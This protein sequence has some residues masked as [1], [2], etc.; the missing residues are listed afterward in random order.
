MNQYQLQYFTA[1]SSGRIVR[2]GFEPDEPSTLGWSALYRRICA[3]VSSDDELKSQLVPFL[4]SDQAGRTIQILFVKNSHLGNRIFYYNLCR[5][6]KLRRVESPLGSKEMSLPEMTQ[7]P[8][9]TI[10]LYDIMSIYE[11]SPGLDFEPDTE[12]IDWKKQRIENKLLYKINLDH[13]VK[14]LDSS[15]W[16]RYIPL[17]TTVEQVGETKFD[18]PE[19]SCSFD[20]R[21]AALLKK[22]IG[23]YELGLYESVAA[24]TTLEFNC[25]MLLNSFIQKAGDRGHHE[26]VT[27]FKF[28]SETVMEQKCER[29]IQF[30]EKERESGKKLSDLRWNMLMVDDHSDTP[31]SS[32]KGSKQVNSNSHLSNKKSIIGKLL[33]A[34]GKAGNSRLNIEATGITSSDKEI[35]SQGVKKLKET[36][37]D[38]ILLD[39]LLGQSESNPKLKAYGHEFLL[40]M[41]TGSDRKLLHRGPMGR[42]WVFPISSFPHAFTDKLH[43][44]NIDGSNR[45]WYIA[46][47]GDPITTPELFRTNFYRLI[48]RQITEYYLHEAALTRWPSQFMGI[49]DKDVWRKAVESQIHIEQ[50][51]LKLLANHRENS[52]FMEE[53]EKFLEKQ[54][55][56]LA[57]WKNLEEWLKKVEQYKRGNSPAE[58]ITGLHVL[59]QSHSGFESVCKS[60]EEQLLAFTYNA[61]TSLLERAIHAKTNNYTQVDFNDEPLFHFPGEL[62]K[63]FSGLKDLNVSG[64]KLSGLP[65]SIAGLLKLRTLNLSNNSNLMHIP[66]SDMLA[67]CVE[68]RQLNLRGT[69]I[70]QVLVEKNIEPFANSRPEVLNLL[71]AVQEHCSMLNSEEEKGNTIFIS[72]AREASIMKSRLVTHLV[73]LRRMG[74]VTIWDDGETIPGQEWNA[75]I[76]KNLLSAQIILLLID[77]DFMASNY[78]WEV[79]IPLA[80]ERHEQKKCK[81]IPIYVNHIYSGVLT[82][83]KYQSLPMGPEEPI[84]SFSNQDRAW[85]LVAAGVMRVVMSLH[86]K[87]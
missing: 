56:Y 71:K 57:F 28:H 1:D 15:I 18:P 80:Q 50:Q 39:Y 9:I 17:Y 40:E 2:L 11:E 74:L 27:P 35:I 33:T 66:A 44:L 51:K 53:M 7:C 58:L 46:Y 61:E 77:A 54:A 72:Y 79:E 67:H 83:K 62:P 4:Q 8:I 41:A 38:I 12:I 14:F 20:K 59:H 16:Q 60:L 29:L 85:S 25:R 86:D 64:C 34:T 22:I 63:V 3:I 31:L 45:R 68:L 43:Q 55:Q 21:M 6:G 76:K 75:E 23:Y 82:L 13:R 32:I 37:Y 65:V 5:H 52:P 70:G 42:F 78:I 73:P 19:L 24:V 36:S 48:L 26:T 81:I 10:G 87:S 49:K 30:F 47:G 69:H 84:T